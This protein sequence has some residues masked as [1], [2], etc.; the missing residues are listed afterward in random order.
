MK[1]KASIV[2]ISI[3]L[4][5]NNLNGQ[6]PV[7]IKV[8]FN[9]I[10]TIY[11]GSNNQKGYFLPDDNLLVVGDDYNNNALNT[12]ERTNF[13]K[14]FR[15]GTLNNRFGRLNFKDYLELYHK[16]IPP[17]YIDWAIE[18]ESGK[19]VFRAQVPEKD[20]EIGLFQ[21]SQFVVYD[22]IKDE[23][24]LSFSKD[25]GWW[26]PVSYRDKKS[27]ILVRGSG[28]TYEY[29]SFGVIEPKKHFSFKGDYL[30]AEIS[31]S[32]NFLL[33]VNSNKRVEIYNIDQNKLL[34]SKQIDEGFNFHCG[35]FD[36]SGFWISYYFI[37]KT[38]GDIS[39]NSILL[40]VYG[41][42]VN[43]KIHSG[44]KT[45]G[46]ILKNEKMATIMNGRLLFLEENKYLVF[47][48]SEYPV[49]ISFNDDASLLMASFNSGLIKVFDTDSLK[50]KGMMFHPDSR[51]H[52]LL[53][54]MGNFISNTDIE[55]HL[56]GT[57]N[58]EIM[59]LIEF[60]QLNNKP[61]EVLKIFGKPDADH[62]ALLEKSATIR[63]K[64]LEKEG[65]VLNINNS[66]PKIS[67]VQFDGQSILE[68]T[69][70]KEIMVALDISDENA[71]LREVVFKLNGVTIRN[72]K[73]ENKAPK[74]I[75]SSIHE[76]LPLIN[77]ENFIEIYVTNDIGI[78]S[79]RI[80]RKIIANQ[81]DEKSKLFI[82]SIGISD[83]R[84]AAYN[85]TFAD[86]D[87]MDI[88][89]LYGDPNTVDMEE[90]RKRF[91][92]NRYYVANY[93]GNNGKNDIRNY[94]GYFSDVNR[95]FQVDYNG[96]FWLDPG[97]GD[98]CFLWDF[99]KSLI[100]DIIL[101]QNKMEFDFYSYGTLF[102]K[103]FHHDPD[104]RYFYFKNNSNQWYSLD[105]KTRVVKYIE[106]PFEK[107]FFPIENGAW[108]SIAYNKKTVIDGD[109]RLLLDIRIAKPSAKKWKYTDFNVVFEDGAY[110]GA[111]LL[112][113]SPKGDYFLISVLSDLWLVNIE[114]GVIT[115]A[116]IDNLRHNIGGY[117]CFTNDGE[118]LSH[119]SVDYEFQDANGENRY[120]CY[121]YNIAEKKVD[122]TIV[123]RGLQDKFGLNIFN[124]NLKWVDFKEPIAVR[125][126]V[127][128]NSFEDRA[129][130][131]T[132]SFHNNHITTLVN[133]QAT[134]ASILYKLDSIM[135]LT[136][137]N[138]QVIVFMAGHG[139]LDDSI[140]YYFAPHDMDF[141]K[142]KDKGISYNQ[143]IHSLQK[144]Q[145]IKKLLIL[146]SCHSGD[147]MDDKNVGLNI[148]L[149]TSHIAEQRGLIL[150][151][152]DT[153]RN[154][155][156]SEMMDLLFGNA[157]SDSGITVLAATSGTDVALE[158]KELSN[159]AFTSAFIE[160]LDNSF[161]RKGWNSLNITEM[162]AGDL[163][164]EF[165]YKIQ[166][167]VYFKTNGV[168]IMNIRE[169]NKQAGIKVW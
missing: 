124:G 36:E 105:L 127:I 106:I 109:N 11:F 63:K 74:G 116:H 41:N 83:Y 117:Y 120:K 84:Q 32:G 139:V 104:N 89:L 97:K 67:S 101:P 149:S 82:L 91:F 92:S 65:N 38:T 16:V 86:K 113:A 94:K 57:K 169:L 95:L 118:T 22:L 166:K 15:Q 3:L 140:T 66:R 34:Y 35:T 48:E 130:A 111:E 150:V 108:T 72:K 26:F 28:S 14:F 129:K 100:H 115:K 59:D 102:S 51:S 132:V 90:Y 9:N 56:T 160:E 29:S 125:P 52:V 25:W 103:S 138:D 33:L 76:K 156:V 157:S 64:R 68:Y 122:S 62:Y 42:N 123:Y 147:L 40:E 154:E 2:F 81:K 143:I 114:N 69:D 73:L 1:I 128:H 13:I 43:E 93:L 162:S 158:N 77:G 135:K 167:S 23:V 80:E 45:N 54:T 110:F 152:S 161:I 55:K 31:E 39:A 27:R 17:S 12:Q 5:A 49:Q 50:L 96:N 85:L 134:G 165:L 4:I 8:F 20:E 44:I 30:S 137:I 58:G 168:Q 98:T 46:L 151:S 78:N 112:A 155:K 146:D 19:I 119:L 145:S 136:G 37:D 47:S 133:E 163:T 10:Q 70:K 79:D 141:K 159:G 142:P 18:V 126:H 21:K 60:D 6:L 53:D 148:N 144:S 153:K 61:H 107:N 7:D 87:A 164:E 131:K 24:D 99:E 121:I 75:I 71:S 88:S